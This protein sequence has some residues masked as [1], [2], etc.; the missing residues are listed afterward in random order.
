MYK[1]GGRRYVDSQALANLSAS[2]ELV[3]IAGGWRM[4]AD[5]GA[6]VFTVVEGRERLPRQRGSVYAVAAEGRATVKD[7]R[8]AWVRTGVVEAVAT[9]DAWPGG[10]PKAKSCGSSCACA[11]CQLRRHEPE[12]EAQP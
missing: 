9:L 3:P 11:P 7:H 12:E 1:V 8:E 10:E 6:L 4:L 5:H 2:H